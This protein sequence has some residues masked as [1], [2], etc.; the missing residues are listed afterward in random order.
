MKFTPRKKEMTM[1]LSRHFT[2]EKARFLNLKNQLVSSVP[3]NSCG[4]PSAADVLQKRELIA[5]KCMHL[6]YLNFRY[7]YYNSLK[8]QHFP[9]GG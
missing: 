6:S 2:S 3:C 7:V 9:A 1:S 8:F 5:T 4:R